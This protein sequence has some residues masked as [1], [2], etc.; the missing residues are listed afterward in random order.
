MTVLMEAK[1]DG[2]S[3][4]G[5]PR[6]RFLDHAAEIGLDLRERDQQ[7]DCC[8]TMWPTINL[9]IEDTCSNLIQLP[10]RNKYAYVV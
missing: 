7:D 6:R 5:K 4:S 8:R 9:R 2:R 3:T 1:I 10:T